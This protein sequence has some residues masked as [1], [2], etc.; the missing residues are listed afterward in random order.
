MKDTKAQQSSATANSLNGRATL[1]KAHKRFEAVGNAQGKAL[2]AKM[3]G[4]SSKSFGDTAR[5]PSGRK[6]RS[7]D[8]GTA[9]E[10]GPYPKK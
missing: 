10:S 5:H 2:K 6:W 3:G 4:K 7:N 1:A 8:K 9:F